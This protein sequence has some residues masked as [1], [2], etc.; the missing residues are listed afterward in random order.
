[1]SILLA[2]GFSYVFGLSLVGFPRCQPAQTGQQIPNAREDA[3]C[4]LFSTWPTQRLGQNAFIWFIPA[5]VWRLAPCLLLPPLFRLLSSE[6]GGGLEQK[7]ACESV[8]KKAGE[9][10]LCFAQ[11]M[12]YHRPADGD[13]EKKA[14]QQNYTTITPTSYLLLS[15]S[16]S[17][18]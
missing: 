12:H 2:A 8:C 6:A 14:I 10:A 16:L 9:N 4:W 3:S 11:Q 15:Y 18:L 5:H 1:M 7:G 13:W 17:S